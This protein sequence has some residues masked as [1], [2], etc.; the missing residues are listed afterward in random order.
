MGEC[1][2]DIAVMMQTTHRTVYQVIRDLNRQL[3]IAGAEPDGPDLAEKS[4]ELAESGDD[5]RPHYKLTPKQKEMDERREL[6]DELMQEKD[7]DG[8]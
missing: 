5:G 3:G 1:A 2:P 7:E 6:I 4:P 8:R